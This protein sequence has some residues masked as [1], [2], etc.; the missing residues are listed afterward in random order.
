MLNDKLCS[1]IALQFV[2]VWSCLVPQELVCR[3][4]LP[5]NIAQFNFMLILSER[6]ADSDGVKSAC[7]HGINGTNSPA[8]KKSTVAEVGRKGR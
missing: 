6:E 5:G 2:H 7:K 3:Q 8:A 4:L 1:T